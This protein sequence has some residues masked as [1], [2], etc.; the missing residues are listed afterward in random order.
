MAYKYIGEALHTNPLLQKCL[1]FSLDT[2]KYVDTLEAAKKFIIAKQLLRSATS[3]GANAVEAQSAESKADFIHKLKIADKEAHETY[4]WLTICNAAE[5]YPSAT[6]L[7]Q[8]LNDILN[9]LSS[10]IRSSKTN[11]S[12]QSTT[13]SPNPTN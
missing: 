10:I 12:I 1:A 11:T 9:L 13:N 3:I 2:L 4:Y 8:L 7:I 5:N 6:H